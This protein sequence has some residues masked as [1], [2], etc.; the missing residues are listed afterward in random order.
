VLR[1]RARHR[2][3][4]PEALATLRRL[5]PLAAVLALAFP[6]GA[7]A[8]RSVESATVG[9]VHAELSY[10]KVS[11]VEFR[12][13]RLKIVRAGVTALDKEVPAP[14]RD[15][16]TIPAAS[17]TGDSLVI[18]DLDGDGE[19]EVLVDLF[20]GGAHCCTFTQIY[21]WNDAD[22]TYV[23]SKH[24]WRDSGYTL[25]DLDNDG[26][27]EFHSYDARFA[28][29]F[30]AYAFSV[31]PVQIWRY[32]DGHLT[33]V[34]RRFHR[35][36][37]RDARMNK[38]LYRRTRDNSDADI[39]GVLAAYLADKYLLGQGRSGWLLVRRAV[40]RGE[41]HKLDRFDSN[42][43]GRS[44]LRRLRRFLKRTNYIH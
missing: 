23:R 20:T 26:K 34:T 8:A 44:Y 24:G 15:C 28:F 13:V 22:I 32:R 2:H 27:P 6:A 3:A 21:A 14:C 12:D 41:V 9:D 35:E 1:R 33:D 18:H 4:D 36:L 43:A 5:V 10:E 11:D 39:R 38:R 31:F 42:P 25:R 17:D 29:E 37:R 7:S 40:R 30:T 19:P 16:P